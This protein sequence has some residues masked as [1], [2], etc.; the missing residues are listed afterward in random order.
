MADLLDTIALLE[1]V[2]ATNGPNEIPRAMVGSLLQEHQAL[3]KDSG[4]L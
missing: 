3:V 2:V 1:E 4:G